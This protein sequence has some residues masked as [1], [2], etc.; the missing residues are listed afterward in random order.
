M[1]THI[2]T[3]VI[4]IFIVAV[5][6]T[7]FTATETFAQTTVHLAI[8]DLVGLEPLE[9]EF[10]AFREVLSE[11]SGVNIEF[12]PVMNRTA[13]VEAV[14]SQKVDFVLTGPAEYV[15]FKKLADIQ[16]V[17]AFSRP[18][19]FCDIV[20]LSAS[21][22]TSVQALKGKKVAFGSIGSTSKH[23]APMQV[24]ADNGL[25]PRR[26][27]HA[28]H[29]GIEEGWDMMKTG[30]VDA[31]AGT[32]DKFLKMRGQERELPAGAFKVLARSSDLPNDVLLAGK[33]VDAALIEKF[34][35]IFSEH[36]QELIDA[37]LKG[38]DNQKYRGMQFLTGVQDSNYNYVREM[39]ATI[40]FPQ[41]SEFVGE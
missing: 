7:S 15:V 24:L 19:Y 13:A 35:Q 21:G 34:R 2:K 37:I 26:D 40:G 17:I 36:A 22:M 31:W 1:P 6:V 39:Y 18:D 8:T 28:I 32:H 30:A 16:P 33:H 9:R 3:L 38:D 20:A 11:K 10:G 12:F 25:K 5:L 29:A 4:H 23:L 41:F 14:K 27:I